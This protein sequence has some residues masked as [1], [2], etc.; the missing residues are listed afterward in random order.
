M[1]SNIKYSSDLK[2]AYFNKVRYVRDDKT[3]YYLNSW[4]RKRLH[5][6]VWEFYNGDILKDCHIHHTDNNKYNNEIE[7]LK[8]ILA[9]DHSKIHAKEKTK[10]REWFVNFHSKGIEK[11]KDWHG[12]QEGKKWHKKH[13]N[14]IK[15]RFNKKIKMKC[16]MC[17]H[18]FETTYHGN[19]K[20]CSNNCKSAY[21]RKIGIDNIEKECRY[22]G[23]NFTTNKY[24]KTETCSRVCTNK[25]VWEK[26]KRQT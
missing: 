16:E 5:R 25:I 23:K 18:E 13:Y 24:R 21:R 17:N 1:W 9:S 26:R 3:G 6:A 11:A 14:K 22:C 15:S 10:D 20:F 2:Y 12:S 4:K 8:C 19:N 7:N